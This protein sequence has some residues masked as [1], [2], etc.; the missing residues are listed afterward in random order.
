MRCEALCTGE[1][2]LTGLTADTNTP[3]FAGKLFALGEQLQRVHVVGDQ[4]EE[5]IAALQRASAQ[6]D[7]LLVSGGLGPTADDLTAECAAKAA[8][9]PLVERTEVVDHLRA[10]A[11]ARNFKLT[12]NNLKQALVPHGAELV[13]HPMGS[14]PMFVLTLGRC[15][16]YF[17]AGV[18]REYRYLVDR[19]VLPRIEQ[20][21]LQE[22]HR[23]FRAARLLKTVG[24]AESHLDARV[25]PLAAAHPQVALG[26]RTQAPE[27]HLKLIA[28][29]HTQAAAD[30]ALADAE[31]AARELVG[32][33]IFGQDDETLGGQ[34]G[35]LLRERGATLA[36]A[37]SCTGGRLAELLTA[38]PGASDYFVGG[39]VAYANSMKGLWAAVPE[40]LLARVGAV[41]WEVAEQL[42]RGI[43]DAAGTTYGLSVTGI[44]GPTGGTP[45]KPV[46]TVLVGLAGP[47][48]THHR[49]FAFRGDRE[50]IRAFSAHGA[51]DFLRRELQRTSP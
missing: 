26:F 1:E 3:Y 4:R 51:M 29:G 5:I 2:F 48:G 37:E 38:P 40:G 41:S 35:K 22:P 20:R 46:G 17:V 21:R 28:S 42:A 16:T 32:E 30:R 24:L 36:V 13:I 50:L 12:S 43:R 31:K 33:F 18:P 9:V 14:A 39:V 7:V 15:V 8:G 47:S 11:A 6:A 49:A 44:A 23:T 27:N 10:L 45:E 25:A 34:V 19:E